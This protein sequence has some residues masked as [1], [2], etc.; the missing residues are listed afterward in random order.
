L[1]TTQWVVERKRISSVDGLWNI[2]GIPGQNESK[3]WKLI[4]K[5]T[6]FFSLIYY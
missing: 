6:D 4:Y 3:D 5:K 2:P 1:E